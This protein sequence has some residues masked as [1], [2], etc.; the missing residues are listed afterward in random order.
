MRYFGL[1]QAEG[2][3]SWKLYDG[4]E[5]DS[6]KQLKTTSSIKGSTSYV[7]FPASDIK[8]MAKALKKIEKGQ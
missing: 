7:L 6:L 3:R 5:E 1:A 4:S 2:F 8:D